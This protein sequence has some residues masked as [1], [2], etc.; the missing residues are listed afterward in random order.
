[1]AAICEKKR[2]EIIIRTLDCAK[3]VTRRDAVTKIQNGEQDQE[4][5]SKIDLSWD[6]DEIEVGN[7]FDDCEYS[8]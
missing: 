8:R 3:Q 4:K 6:L 1:M 5:M 2:I 7:C